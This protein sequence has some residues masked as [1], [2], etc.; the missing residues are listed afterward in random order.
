MNGDVYLLC[1]FCISRKKRKKALNPQSPL[2]EKIS[3]KVNVINPDRRE[4]GLR[5]YNFGALADWLEARLDRRRFF[6]SLGAAHAMVLLA[7]MAGAD[8][9]RA[10]LAGL[11]HDCGRVISGPD[12][13]GF[14]EDA[15][16]PLPPEDACFPKIW[17]AR[18]GAV[19]AGRLI[20]IP[21]PAISRAVW[22]HPTGA[23]GMD[24]LAR[25]LFVADY[26]EPSRRFDGVGDLRELARRDPEAAFCEILRRKIAHV[27]AKGDPVHPDALAAME[28]YCREA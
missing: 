5:E 20:G 7:Q 10:A 16:T 26:I 3:S 12:T 8:P 28:Y 21:D 17:H 24:I 6:H 1:L 13:P 2:F 14:M 4:T 27:A 11:V 9:A 25:L 18:S 15:G 23:P 19:L 22:V